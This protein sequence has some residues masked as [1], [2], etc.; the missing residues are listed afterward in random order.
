MCDLSRG[1]AVTRA[2][3]V[4]PATSA[5]MTGELVYCYH[6][7]AIIQST[8][9]FWLSVIAAVAGFVL[10]LY[11]AADFLLVSPSEPAVRVIPGCVFECLAGLF[12]RQSARVRQRAT[13]L[14][15]RLRF[16]HQRSSSI[17]L[18]E[19]IEE[20]LLRDLV[21]AQAVSYLSDI[22]CPPK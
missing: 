2:G 19:S 14:F 18:I 6:R 13:E 16:D 11:A 15:D 21:K 20:P 9:L 1:K 12:F 10:I 8:V 4:E 3:H 7:Q 17:A 5:Q 22:R